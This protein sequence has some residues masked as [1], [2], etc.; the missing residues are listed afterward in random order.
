[1]V[2]PLTPGVEWNRLWLMA[3]NVGRKDDRQ[4]EYAKWITLQASRSLAE[5]ISFG[6][7][8]SPA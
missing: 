6:A 2:G 3:R 8:Q 7:F 5:A 1:M 4:S